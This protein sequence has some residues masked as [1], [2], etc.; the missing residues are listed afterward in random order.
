MG[1]TQSSTPI[2]TTNGQNAKLGN[3]DGGTNSSGNFLG[4]LDPKPNM[5]FGVP[6][7]DNSLKSSTL[8]ST[9]LFLDRLDLQ[10]RPYQQS[11]PP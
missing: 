9:G 10:L 1:L 3:D 6:N 4:R 8:T 7:N 11:S 2:S 5:P